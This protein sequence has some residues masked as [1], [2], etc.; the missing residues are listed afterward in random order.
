M[1]SS[2]VAAPPWSL[3]CLTDGRPADGR[4]A[5]T[6]DD[7]DLIRGRNGAGRACGHEDD[8][9]RPWLYERPC[10]ARHGRET[11]LLIFNAEPCAMES[12]QRRK[13][14]R[15]TIQACEKTAD[16]QDE[17]R[18]SQDRSR[19]QPHHEAESLHADAGQVLAASGTRHRQ[20]RSP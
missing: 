14:L 2:L 11:V 15:M 12:P 6:R 8:G 1:F 4:N 17:R 13:G 5:L 18:T 3:S 7:P 9:M 19:R 10:G 20:R 16:R